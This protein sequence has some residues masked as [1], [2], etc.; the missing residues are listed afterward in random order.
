DADMRRPV[1]ALRADGSFYDTPET[2]WLWEYEIRKHLKD[3]NIE[4]I[5]VWS[6]AWWRD[7]KEEARKLAGAVLKA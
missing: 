2:D 6:A 7:A 4:Y 5:S 3:K 1:A